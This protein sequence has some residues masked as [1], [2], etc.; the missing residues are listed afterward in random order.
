LHP[1]A[2]LAFLLDEGL[3]SSFLTIHDDRALA[4]GDVGGMALSQYFT[5]WRSS[6]FRA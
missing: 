6:G 5:P 1:Q 3:R 4:S 2:A